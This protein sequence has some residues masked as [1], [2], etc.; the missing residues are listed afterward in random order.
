MLTSAVGH[1]TRATIYLR[2]AA[3]SGAEAE[4]VSVAAAVPSGHN[5]VL[6]LVEDDGLVRAFAR[7]QVESLG[8][9]VIEAGNGPD[10]LACLSVHPEIGLLFTDIVMR[11]G[12]SGQK[13]AE[14][15]QAVRPGLPVLYTSGYTED[16]EA[17]EGRLGPDVLFLSKP[18]LRSQL[19]EKLFQ[20]FAQLEAQC[21]ESAQR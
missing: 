5:Q 6:L 18:Y 7:Q 3:A 15:A 13:L 8:Y 11:G 16:T 4:T 2:R 1:G 10:A 14:A 17:R 20:G 9:R 12:M 19:A 21:S